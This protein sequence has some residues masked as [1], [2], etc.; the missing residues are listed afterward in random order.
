PEGCLLVAREEFIGNNIK[1]DILSDYNLKVFAPNLNT[2]YRLYHY[3]YN[4]EDSSKLDII[5]FIH[6]LHCILIE[7][8]THR[9]DTLAK[10]AERIEFVTVGGSKIKRKVLEY[11]KC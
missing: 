10:T 5:K 3:N 11:L 9:K 4:F 1:F 2:Y 7:F 6:A 8:R